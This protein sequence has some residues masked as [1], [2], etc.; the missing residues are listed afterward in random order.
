MNQIYSSHIRVPEDFIYFL[1][2]VKGSDRGKNLCENISPQ[3]YTIFNRED[4]ISLNLYYF[5]ILVFCTRKQNHLFSKLDEDFFNNLS[6]Y[7]DKLK[8][9]F[10]YSN[11]SLTP[12]TIHYDA[13]SS[14]TDI[15][16]KKKI[17]KLFNTNDIH[18]K[19]LSAGNID[20]KRRKS[21]TNFI[22]D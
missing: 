21:Y 4:L 11:G 14:K 13:L 15:M 10:T 19:E 9:N 5:H 12:I 2:S 8:I 17:M 6:A 22:F 1:K 18:I 16:L 7:K 20:K 3:Q